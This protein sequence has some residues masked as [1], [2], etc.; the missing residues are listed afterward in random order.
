[1]PA[2]YHFEPKIGLEAG[3]DGLFFVRQILPQA[4]N[5]LTPHGVLIV[6]VGLSQ[7]QLLERYPTVP[8]TW[9]EFQRGGEGVFLLTVDQLRK[10]ADVF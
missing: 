6:E 9:L 10:Y 3:V 4:I 2:E 5:Y 7:A 1:M 8:F